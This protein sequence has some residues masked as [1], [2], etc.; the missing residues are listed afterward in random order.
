MYLETRIASNIQHLLYRIPSSCPYSS[1]WQFPAKSKSIRANRSRTFAADRVLFFFFLFA[2]LYNIINNRIEC[3][4]EQRPSETRSTC[5]RYSSPSLAIPLTTFSLDVG[6]IVPIKTVKRDKLSL[7]C[8]LG[9]REL[10]IRRN[11][12]SRVIVSPL[13]GQAF[14]KVRTVLAETSIGLAKRG[15]ARN[16][17]ISQF[18]NL[19]WDFRCRCC[20]RKSSFCKLFANYFYYRR[21]SYLLTLREAIKICACSVVLDEDWFA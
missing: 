16:I 17:A 4:C 15:F 8:Q 3:C 1:I 9:A 14:S 20:H 10:E 21:W 12:L 2:L 6:W 7:V 18:R 13:D 11:G 5:G 19:S